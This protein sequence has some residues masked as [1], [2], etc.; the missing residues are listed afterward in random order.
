MI[1]R[2]SFFLAQDGSV[3]TIPNPFCP[4]SQVRNVLSS[5]IKI[6]ILRGH[7]SFQA[8]FHHQ[9]M[10]LSKYSSVRASYPNFP[11]RVIV[12]LFLF[13]LSLYSWFWRTMD[14]ELTYKYN[15]TIHLLGYPAN[16][17]PVHQIHSNRLILV[18]YRDALYFSKWIILT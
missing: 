6:L 4:L 1:D 13:N 12:D 5:Q 15:W 2:L 18:N 10:S 16:S 17:C 8:Y 14:Y 3:G 7:S 9:S 11:M